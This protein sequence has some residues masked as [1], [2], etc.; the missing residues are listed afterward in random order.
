MR[1]LIADDSPFILSLL[2]EIVQSYGYEVV[3]AENGIEA[4]EKIFK[5]P[6]DLIFLDVIMPYMTGYQVSRVLKSDPVTRPIPIII[7]TSKSEAADKFWAYQVGADHYI[8]K[9]ENVD[10]IVSSIEE[11]LSKKEWKRERGEVLKRDYSPLNIVSKVNDLLDKKLYE[12][13]ILNEVGKLVSEITDFKSVIS[14][15]GELYSKL[16]SY[17]LLV[18]FRK[19]T[20]SLM[21]AIVYVNKS[22]SARRYE[23]MREAVVRRL[24]EAPSP[25]S[26]QVRDIFFGSFSPELE[27]EAEGEE[28]FHFEVI[29][30]EN[31]AKGAVAIA[32][33]GGKNLSPEEI[34]RLQILSNYTFLVVESARLYEK[35]QELSIRD[36]LTDLF[37]HSF[38]IESLKKEFR[39]AQ[40]YERHLTL[41]MADIDY[42]K[43]VN[44]TYGHQIGDV[45]LR[46][47]AQLIKNNIRDIDLAGRYGGEEFLVILP[48]TG[49]EGAMVLAERMRKKIENLRIPLTP[50]GF[51]VTISMGCVAF[52]HPNADSP[53][54]LLKMADT[55]LYAAKDGGR[56]QVQL[57]S[58]DMEKPPEQTA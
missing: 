14:K 29:M 49:Q 44:D 25:Q 19:E 43:R 31:E 11:V 38:V 50:E 51:R 33:E 28:G 35:V 52:P 48:G 10:A 23:R 57:Y 3:T 45:V 36:G 47:V 20:A 40:R 16:F 13:T 2:G 54:T 46:E 37:N 32:A 55:A 17:S 42:F 7:L 1:A 58:P 15:L 24:E 18:I 30:G 21:E 22:V 9:D 8:V 34:G 6:P 5:D 41:I 26:L 4:L 39:I 27:G 53:A 56:N 12:L